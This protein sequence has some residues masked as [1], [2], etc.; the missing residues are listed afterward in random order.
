MKSIF[1]LSLFDDEPA[2]KNKLG[3]SVRKCFVFVNTISL[4]ATLKQKGW[5]N[6]GNFS[7]YYGAWANDSLQ[8]ILT[9]CEGDLHLVDCTNGDYKTEYR[10]TKNHQP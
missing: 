3:N 5:K 10:E 9:F 6:F 7:V 8:M 2:T 4:D 1:P